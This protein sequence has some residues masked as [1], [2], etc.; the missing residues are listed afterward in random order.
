[1]PSLGGE[2]PKFVE[3]LYRKVLEVIIVIIKNFLCLS[4]HASTKNFQV[5]SSKLNPTVAAVKRSAEV[6]FLNHNKISML[7]MS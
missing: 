6:Q 5:K 7:V 3:S 2:A 4:N 1:M